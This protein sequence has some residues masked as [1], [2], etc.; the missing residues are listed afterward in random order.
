MTG[1]FLLILAST[2]QG[3]PSDPLLLP[4]FIVSLAILI[5]INMALAYTV[6]VGRFLRRER[7]VSELSKQSQ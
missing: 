7:Q 3:N 6:F 4:V 2:F 5:G 1:I